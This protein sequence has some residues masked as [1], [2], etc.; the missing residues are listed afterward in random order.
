MNAPVLNQHAAVPDGGG[1][2]GNDVANDVDTAFATDLCQRMQ[3]FVRTAILPQ[4]SH[5]ATNG[6][7]APQLRQRLYESAR[8][9]GLWGLFYPQSMGGKLTQLAAYLP[10][11]EAEGYSEYGPALVGTHATLDAHMLARH[12][13]ADL[14]QRYLAALAEGSVIPAYGMSEPDSIGS[15]PAT[16]RTR[17]RLEQGQWIIDGRK[18]FISRAAQASFITVVAQT[19]GG[20][21]AALSMI[22]VPTSTPGVQLG[23][24]LDVLGQF[25]AQHEISFDQVAVPQAFM[26]GQPGQGP[27]LMQQ[28]LGLGRSLR[29]MHWLGLAQRCFDLMC[30]RIVSAR[31]I[32]ARLPEKQLVRQHVYAVHSAITS[33]RA[34]LQLAA[35]QIDAGQASDLAVNSAK[36][37]AS[38][39]LSLAADRAIQ[40]YGAEGLSYLTPLGSIYRNARS[41][42]ILD[43]TDDALINAIGKRL[44]EQYEARRVDHAASDWPGQSGLQA[45][46]QSGQQSGP[47]P[48]L[49]F[50][51]QSGQQSDPQSNQSAKQIRSAA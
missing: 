38:N 40:I 1:A 33:A 47:Q 32:T 29:A 45:D 5:L 24:A 18:W 19:G 6:P 13:G 14:R 31:G 2:G 41:N 16:I 42:H 48:D 27:A 34:L 28:R 26:L 10:V 43:G 39:A 15:I 12:A 30:E 49:Q 11:G 3:A 7:D 21:E 8:Q 37:A 9:A 44:L 25:G 17:A 35:Q 51:H 23:R 50:S 4:E 46:L 20:Q 22:V 36:L